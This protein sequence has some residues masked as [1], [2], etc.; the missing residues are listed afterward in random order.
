MMPGC[1]LA[2]DRMVGIMAFSYATT[3]VIALYLLLSR[4]KWTIIQAVDLEERRHRAKTL[5]IIRLTMAAFVIT[6]PIKPSYLFWVVVYPLAT[7]VSAASLGTAMFWILLHLFRQ[8]ILA[9]VSTLVQWAF[10]RT[11][12]GF[13]I[14]DFAYYLSNAVLQLVE[15]DQECWK[16]PISDIIF[17][18]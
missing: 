4:R 10:I 13:I 1:V 18:I 2:L 9:R 12:L 17:V 8:E 15:A 7:S 5:S 3:G 16:D 6:A 14:A 11:V